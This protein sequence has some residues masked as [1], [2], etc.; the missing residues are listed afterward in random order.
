MLVTVPQAVKQKQVLQINLIASA[1]L[2]GFEVTV[3]FQLKKRDGQRFGS[4]VDQ[5]CPLVGALTL[6]GSEGDTHNFAKS[7][8][9]PHVTGARTRGTTPF[10][11]RHWVG[12]IS[13]GF[14]DLLLVLCNIGSRGSPSCLWQKTRV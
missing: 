5:E 4:K 8:K 10:P 6:L 3:V 2:C 11:I 12:F 7:S 1:S 13:K 9:T 14:P